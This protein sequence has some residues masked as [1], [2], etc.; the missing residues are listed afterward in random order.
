MDNKNLCFSSIAAAAAAA[1]AKLLQSC[2]TL[3][4][5]IDGCPPGS[6]PWDSSGKNTRVGCH[7]LLQCMKSESEVAQ[8]CLTLRDPMYYSPCIQIVKTELNEFLIS[9]TCTQQ[10]H[11]STG[12][13]TAS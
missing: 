8:S 1:A 11:S 2:L 4:D 3:C 13:I 9:Y 5:P 12:I 10:V 7:F 6:R